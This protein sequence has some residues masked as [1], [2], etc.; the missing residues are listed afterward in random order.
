MEAYFI[1]ARLRSASRLN[2]HYLKIFDRE[3]EWKICMLQELYYAI[4]L[5]FKSNFN[6]SNHR[7][8]FRMMKGIYFL[9]EIIGGSNF[10][11]KIQIKLKKS[12]NLL[13]DRRW[14]NLSCHWHPLNMLVTT[15]NLHPDSDFLC[16]LFFVWCCIINHNLKFFYFVGIM[17]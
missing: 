10:Q 7:N 6:I 14:C 9:A 13:A 8:I 2:C 17:L 1:H 3:F 16:I 5:C 12:F 15:I 11:P 4:L